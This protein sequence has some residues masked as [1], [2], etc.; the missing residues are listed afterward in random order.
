MSENQPLVVYLLLLIGRIILI[1]YNEG[2]VNTL[3]FEVVKI[4]SLMK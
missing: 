4:V 2:V 3:H 1:S